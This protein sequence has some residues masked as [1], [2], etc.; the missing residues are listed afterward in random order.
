[1]FVN[2]SHALIP[3]LESVIDRVLRGM[4][5]RESVAFQKVVYLRL[6]RQKTVLKAT[7]KSSWNNER[8]FLVFGSRR[9]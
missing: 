9:I 7:H 8:L 6:F 3:R 4:L 1:M 5:I 2:V